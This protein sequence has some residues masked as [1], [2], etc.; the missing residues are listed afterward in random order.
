MAIL[1]TVRV[2]P[3]M[4][5][6]MP[7]LTE[8]AIQRAISYVLSKL[9]ELAKKYVPERTGKLLGS[10]SAWQTTRGI[11]F[12]FHA[13]DPVYGED[14]A[15]VVEKGRPRGKVLTPKLKKA[16]RFEWPYKSGQF[17]YMKRT[18]QGAMSGRY[19]AEAIKFEARDLLIDA[20]SDELMMMG[21]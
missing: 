12:G 16:M 8:D 5:R 11:R 3:E 9:P 10:L 7:A 14:Y 15:G 1:R 19:Y 4:L 6:Q 20:L 18:I 2:T 21:G 17:V 13:E